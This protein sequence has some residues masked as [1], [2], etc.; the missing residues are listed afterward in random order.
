MNVNAKYKYPIIICG[1]I[2]LVLIQYKGFIPLAYKAAQSGLFMKDTDDEGS[3]EATT[4]DHT[5]SAFKQCNDYIKGELD[6]KLNVNFSPTPI[7]TWGLG[8][9]EYLVN[10]EITVAENTKPP[11]TERYACRIHYNKESDA[12]GLADKENWS[13]LGISGI[14]EL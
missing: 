14:D 6:S 8:D 13:I 10:A 7:N 3:R 2:A 4:N 11:K 5:E 12:A 9:Y 1:A